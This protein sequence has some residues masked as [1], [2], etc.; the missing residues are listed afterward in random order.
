[1][2]ASEAEVLHARQAGEYSRESRARRCTW[3]QIYPHHAHTPI[4]PTHLPIHMRAHTHTHTHTQQPLTAHTLG[5]IE[6][7]VVFAS[8]E[9]VLHARLAGEEGAGEQGSRATDAAA[10]KI[11]VCI[12]R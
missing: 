5:T 7:E 10:E 6:G 2:L 9:E 8:E 1:M 11:K 4:T 12:H 3:T